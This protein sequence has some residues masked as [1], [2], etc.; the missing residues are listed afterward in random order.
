[1]RCGRL[2]V[3]SGFARDVILVDGSAGQGVP[4]SRFKQRSLSGT[5]G[6]ELCLEGVTDRHELAHLGDNPLL[7]AERCQRDED[8]PES[9]KRNCFLCDAL[10]Q[11]VACMNTIRLSIAS[12]R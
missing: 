9:G 6:F 1:M 8:P 11:A 3:G 4:Q 10:A 7:F 5:T 2:R 12:A